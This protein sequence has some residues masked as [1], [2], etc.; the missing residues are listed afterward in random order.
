MDTSKLSKEIKKD[1]TLKDNAL[2]AEKVNVE[3]RRI[4]IEV[5]DTKQTD[6]FYPQFK[7]KH[8][9]NETNFSIRLLDDDYGAADVRTNKDK[10]EWERA[11]RIARFYNKETGDADGGFEFEVEL[12]E[13]PTTNVLHFSIQTKGFDFFYQPELTPEELDRGDLRP[14]NVIG[15]YAVYHK[16]RKDNIV[17]GK[18][19]ATGK[20][21]HIYRPYVMDANGVKVWCELDIDVESGEAA[22]TIPEDFLD[23]AAYPIIIDPTFGYTTQGAS[24]KS[25]STASAD[26]AAAL[27]GVAITGTLTQINAYI[28]RNTVNS[29]YQLGLESE[30]DTDVE[31]SYVA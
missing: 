28:K 11:G 15:S 20:A 14:E 23:T 17:G 8:W 3:A 9:D 29:T 10:I 22:I 2:S 5:G 26:N 19:Y 30:T 1:F 31:V 13:K 6:L 7:T 27:R 12:A 24:D 16:T 4:E 21:F 18:E 25:I